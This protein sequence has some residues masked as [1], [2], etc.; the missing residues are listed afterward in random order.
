MALIIQGAAE[1]AQ[2]IHYEVDTTLA[3]LGVGGMGQVYRGYRV[4]ER[5][6]VRRDAAVKFLFEDLP[7]SAIERSR[8]EA[9]VIIKNEN[10]VEM[11]GFIEVDETDAAGQVHRRYHVASELLDG[12]GLYDLLRGKT[13]DAAG[14]EIP[15]AQDMYR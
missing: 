2:G 9:S 8:R 11:F 4:D 15:F 5:T 13:T 7:E 1:R 14:E 12:V 6:G 3:P 10:L